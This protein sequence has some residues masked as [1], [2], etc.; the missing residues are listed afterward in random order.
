MDFDDPVNEI[1]CK[2]LGDFQSSDIPFY[3]HTHLL[4][5]T[6]KMTRS[7][8]QWGLSDEAALNPPL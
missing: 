3:P 4:R 1:M 5:W 7:A 8:V 2:P 6:Q